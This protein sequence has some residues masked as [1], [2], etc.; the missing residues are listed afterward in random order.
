MLRTV[1]RRE[2]VA[3]TR[4]VVVVLTILLALLELG[5]RGEAPTSGMRQELLTGLMFAAGFVMFGAILRTLLKG[6]RPRKAEIA[7]FLVWCSFFATHPIGLPLW[8][9]VGLMGN[10]IFLG[11]FVFIELSRL[12]LGGGFTLSPALLF[13]FSFILLITIGTA[14]FMLPKAAVRPL[15]LIEALFTS[16][17]AVCVT[18]LSVFDIGTTLTPMGLWILLLLVQLGG[19]GVMT[20][21]SFFAFF[22]KGSNSLEEQLRIRDLSNTTLGGARRF[23]VQVILFTLAVEAIGAL[24]IFQAVP[25]DQ[26]AT[27]SDRLF[28]SVFHAISAFNNAGFSTYA[29]G[30]YE[31]VM[32]F[33]YALQ[34]VLA[35][36]IVFG[37]LGFGI[38]FN[39]AN[40]LR[41]RVRARVR[42]WT[43]GVPCER[44]PRVVT[45]S[46][47]LVLYTTAG[48]L[49]FGTIAF[50]VFERDNALREHTGWF[51]QLTT[52]FFGSVTPRTAGFNTVNYGTLTVPTLMI[53]IL[54]MYIGASPGSTGGGIKT[55]TAAVA[56]FNI[57][58]TGRGRERV[59]TGGREIGVM[60]VRRAFAAIVLSL[61]FLGV[62]IT[63]VASLEKEHGLLPVAFEC[64]SAFSTVGLSTGITAELD[65]A[66]RVALTLVMFVGRV[67]ALT[68]LIGVLK[69]VE[70]SNYRY[71]KEDILIN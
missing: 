15:G 22:F 66:A 33:N 50:W 21:T 27:F 19:L 45:L 4:L 18:G 24:F 62:S 30:L 12:E 61:I 5:Y 49:F 57:F 2:V 20:F 32:R 65:D 48:L 29:N 28:F 38:I 42:T 31:P 35:L 55:S 34:W 58:S 41:F 36:M 51:G 56:L 14:L 17:S 44:Y 11:L 40:Y 67:S 37:G 1:L 54:L 25:D 63:V 3:L 9:G 23:I 13:T 8:E 26:F 60:T 69:Q 43:L 10:L 47:K 52:S 39:F 70:V 59:E 53:T 68:L 64:F 46:T 7:W 16:T 71:P 6:Q